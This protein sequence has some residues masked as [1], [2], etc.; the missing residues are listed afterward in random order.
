MCA[1]K[2]IDSSLI[3]YRLNG[4]AKGQGSRFQKIDQSKSN[5]K[6]RPNHQGEIGNA[7]TDLSKSVQH[8]L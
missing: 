3:K 7:I 2:N 1:S 4:A 8:L 5:K 6:I